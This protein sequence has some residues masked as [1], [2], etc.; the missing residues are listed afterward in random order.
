MSSINEAGLV[1][2]SFRLVRGSTGN[3]D[4]SDRDF[5]ADLVVFTSQ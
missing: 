2:D 3:S 5:C 4:L 1:P